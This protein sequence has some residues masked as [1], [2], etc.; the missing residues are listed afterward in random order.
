M[1]GT[2]LILQGILSPRLQDRGSD[3]GGR[4]TWMELAGRDKQRLCIISAY[5]VNEFTT[6][7]A[8]D[9]T[10]W[11]AQERYLIQQGRI[12]PNPRKQM[13]EDLKKFIINK[14]DQHQDIILLMG[15]NQEITPT[16]SQNSQ[17]YT[18]L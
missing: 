12:N 10:A 11:R 2:A 6:N 18:S 15:A 8:G 16:K 17:S 14:Q 9:N 13:L 7:T 1:G 3:K 5:R 4:W